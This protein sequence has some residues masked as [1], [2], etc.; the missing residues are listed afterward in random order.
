MRT[1]S[2]H[3]SYRRAATYIYA[4]IQYMG[5]L[6]AAENSLTCTVSTRG[7]LVV[8]SYVGNYIPEQHSSENLRVQAAEKDRFDL[9]RNKISD[10]SSN[11]EKG[12]SIAMELL[13][14][15]VN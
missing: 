3:C 8:C 7:I 4:C 9:V 11:L 6:C 14:Y 10:C 13:L 1:C 15:R 12:G 2:V 5:Q